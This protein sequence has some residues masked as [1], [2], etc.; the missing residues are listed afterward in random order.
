[1]WTGWGWFAC[2]GV[3]EDAGVTVAEPVF[4]GGPVPARL[5]QLPWVD[6]DA[7]TTQVAEPGFGELASVLAHERGPL[8]RTAP[9]PV[10]AAGGGCGGRPSRPSRTAPHSRPGRGFTLGSQASWIP[11][12]NLRARNRLSRSTVA[13]P[14]P[15]AVCKVVVV[16]DHDGGRFY[17]V[18]SERV[19]GATELPQTDLGEPVAAVGGHTEP[20]GGHDV[21]RSTR[22]RH[23]QPS[24]PPLLGATVQIAGVAGVAFH[25]D[26]GGEPV[27]RLVVHQRAGHV[28][29]S[30]SSISRK[31]QVLAG[32]VVDRRDARADGEQERAADLLER[33]LGL[34]TER[35]ARIDV[36]RRWGRGRVQPADH[37]ELGFVDGGADNGLEG[38]GHLVHQVAEARQCPTGASAVRARGRAARTCP[39]RY[40]L[41][42]DR[43]P[44]RPVPRG[45]S[46]AATA[47]PRARA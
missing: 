41:G 25:V 20:Q 36:D 27:Q 46:F 32:G 17:A 39:A 37:L 5:E 8:E 2:A 23:S 35:V 33:G 10:V 38:G 42:R 11:S 40:G 28:M 21:T 1:M 19:A 34:V 47:P 4:V 29:S 14:S 12:L 7:D 18:L 43:S 26:A 30:S 45:L 9:C 6:A 15:R 3:V 16:G 44:T 31:Q 22:T 13:N 24:R